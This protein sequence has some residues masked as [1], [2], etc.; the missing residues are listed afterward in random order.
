MSTIRNHVQLIGNVGDDPTIP[1]LES[2]KKLARFSIAVNERYKNSQGE[3]VESTD[4]LDVVAWGKTAEIAEKYL[5]KGKQVGVGGKLKT[6]KYL[7]DDGNERKLTE[8]V[9]DEILLL[10]GSPKADSK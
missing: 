8:I 5:T 10:G 7:A 2:G 6:R 3:K 4:W 9:A 1:E